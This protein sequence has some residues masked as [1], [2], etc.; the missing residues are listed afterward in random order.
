MILLCEIFDVWG[1]DFIVPLPPTFRYVYILL[2]LEYFSNWVEAKATH[3][4]DAKVVVDVKTNIFVRFGTPK[5][6]ISDRG[7]YFYNHTLNVVL[8]Y[9]VTYQ[10]SIAFHTQTNGKYEAFNWNIKGIIEK[11]INPIK[12]DNSIRLDDVLWAH[13]T[14][15]N[16][17]IRKLPY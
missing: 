14:T 8:K 1:I 7:T 15:Y 11:H 17:L 12:K 4:D 16:T 10:V 6:I 2:A 9:G 13:Q 5:A 3:T